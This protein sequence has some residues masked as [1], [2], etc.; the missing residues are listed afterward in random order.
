[1]EPHTERV[2]KQDVTTN[3]ETAQ[4]DSIIRNESSQAT[5]QVAL[6]S[7]SDDEKK[8]IELPVEPIAK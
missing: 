3:V 5:S 1:M 7:V 4:V 2:S 8:Q 6:P